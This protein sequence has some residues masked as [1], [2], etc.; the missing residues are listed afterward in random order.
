M[1]GKEGGATDVADQLGVVRL[2][3]LNDC[4][5]GDVLEGGVRAGQEAV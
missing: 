4:P 1:G 5:N 3:K 2:Q